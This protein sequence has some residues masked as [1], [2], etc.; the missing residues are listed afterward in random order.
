MSFQWIFDS[1]ETISIDIKPLT[2]ST[3]ALNG[4]YR[5]SN[6][7]NA[8][9]KFTVKLPDG[10]AWSS[11]RQD[12]ARAQALGRFTVA[13]VSLSN[14][15]Y[16]SWLN[17]YQGNCANPAAITATWT[18]GNTITLTGGQAASGFN[19]RA[20]DIIQLGTAQVYQ[21]AADV[22]YNSNTVTLHRPL[23]TAAGS[24]TLKTGSAVT[25]SVKCLEFPDW[26][27]FSRNQVSWSGA[28]VFVE[29]LVA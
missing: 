10:P 29:A 8:P 18:T 19:F 3:M 20:G 16:T 14:S 7:N 28:F 15:G 23:L 27:I 11:L 4:T 17:A 1:A 9:W 21:V 22:P 2:A 25:W 6:L 13:T 12:I 5:T 26:T 24:A